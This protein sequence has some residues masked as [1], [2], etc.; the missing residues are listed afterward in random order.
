MKW[1]DFVVGINF[2]PLF[3]SGNC[4]LDNVYD[5]KFMIF[6]KKIFLCKVDDGS[7]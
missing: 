6:G 5:D 1:L 3:R 2:G 4:D 7:A